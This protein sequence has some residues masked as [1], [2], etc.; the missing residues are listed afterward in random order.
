[1]KNIEKLYA[2]YKAEYLGHNIIDTYFSFIANM[3]IEDHITIIED[4]IIAERFNDQY[5]IE[6]PLT[7]LHQI[8]G[9]GVHKGC[10]VED[11]GKYS[12]VIE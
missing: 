8:L 5:G 1:M 3:I 9:V 6:L 4:E 2:A 7:F 11:H 12:V 10:F